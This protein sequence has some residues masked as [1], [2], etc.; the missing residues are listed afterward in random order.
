MA[1][2]R[3]RPVS[4]LGI[5]ATIAPTVGMARWQGVAHAQELFRGCQQVDGPRALARGGAV[6]DHG[7]LPA[8]GARRHR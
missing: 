7:L 5:V 6:H 4:G 3:M 8:M 1:Q 2:L